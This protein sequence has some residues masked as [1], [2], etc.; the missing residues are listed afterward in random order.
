MGILPELWILMDRFSLFQIV[1]FGIF[2]LARKEQI[3]NGKEIIFIKKASR[4]S[5]KISKYHHN[6]IQILVQKI[7]GEGKNQLGFET[8]TLYFQGIL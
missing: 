5:A 3:S 4:P 7:Q 2:C 8:L 6:G 1:N